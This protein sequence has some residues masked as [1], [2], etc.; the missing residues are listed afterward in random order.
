[1]VEDYI[2]AGASRRFRSLSG[3]RDA[4]LGIEET[5]GSLIVGFVAKK[6]V[7]HRVLGDTYRSPLEIGMSL[8]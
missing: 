3:P 4:L 5:P 8:H 2:H 7:T 6:K 1:M